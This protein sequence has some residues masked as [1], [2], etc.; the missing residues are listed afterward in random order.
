MIV[1]LCKNVSS[2]VIDECID[3][4][5]TTVEAVGRA[6]GAGTDCGGCHCDI[7]EQLGRADC[8]RS[9]TRRLT[10]VQPNTKVA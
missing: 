6:C 4:G 10:V 5:A 1:C 7:E 2:R 3:E 9:G 8:E